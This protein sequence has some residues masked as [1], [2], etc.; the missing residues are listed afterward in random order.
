MWASWGESERERNVEVNTLL[1]L[2][3]G[4]CNKLVY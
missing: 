4:V 1:L 3:I 2:H